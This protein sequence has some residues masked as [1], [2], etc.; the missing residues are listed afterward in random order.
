VAGYQIGVHGERVESLLLG[1]WHPEYQLTNPNIHMPIMTH[2]S[3]TSALHVLKCDRA[4][5]S[6]DVKHRHW[7]SSN[8]PPQH[9]IP[10]S[11]FLLLYL[12]LFS[13]GVCGALLGPATSVKLAMKDLRGPPRFEGFVALRTACIV[14]VEGC[15]EN[16]SLAHVNGRGRTYLAERNETGTISI[17]GGN[18][19]C[20]RC[21]LSFSPDSS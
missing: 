20:F 14:G 5:C 8:L 16:L 7:F 17:L 3:Y 18:I 2:Q 13:S 12:L 11:Q 1:S 19:V 6:P 9:H 21:A 15:G 10:P 4:S